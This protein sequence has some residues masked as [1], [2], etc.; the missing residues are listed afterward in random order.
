MEINAFL[1]MFESVVIAMLGRLSMRLVFG[2]CRRRLRNEESKNASL[3][4]RSVQCGSCLVS[5]IPV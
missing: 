1:G 4:I 5:K 2:G 3:L